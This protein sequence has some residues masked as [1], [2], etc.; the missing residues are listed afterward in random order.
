MARTDGIRDIALSLSGVEERASY[1]GLPSRRTNISRDDLSIWTESIGDPDAT[2][3]LLIAGANASSRMWPEEVV[4]GL[5]ARDYLVLRYDHRDTGRSTVRRFDDHPYSVGDLAADAVAVLDG[6]GIA[7]AHVVGFSL[8]GTIAQLLALD[9]PNRLLSVTVM[10]SAALDIDFAANFARALSGREASDGLPTPDAGVVRHLARRGTASTVEDEIQRRTDVARMLAR[11]GPFEPDEI[12]RR[13]RAA[14]AHAGTHVPPYQ[15]ALAH[16]VPTARGTELARVRTR[17]LVVQG[18][19]DPLNPPPH[20][21]HLARLIPGAQLVEFAELG[22]N[23]PGALLGEI[24]ATLLDHFRGSGATP[25]LAAELIDLAA[26]EERTVAEFTARAIRDADFGQVV[27]ERLGWHPSDEPVQMWAHF[28]RTPPPPWLARWDDTTDDEARALTI[29]VERGTIAL[30]QAV[31]EHGWPGLSLVGADGADAAWM[32][33]MHADAEPALQRRCVDLIE[34]AVATGDADPRHY[35]TLADRVASNDGGAQYFGTLVLPG[36]N[37]P[38]PLLEIVDPHGL[39]RRRS[40]IG[41]PRLD[42]D[43]TEAPGQLPY[44][45]L[46]RTEG[47]HWPRQRP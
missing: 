18:G 43:L 23:L 22:H 44:R 8:G 15:H 37:G 29:A 1:G 45:H 14:I 3:V 11:G 32:L 46:R 31:G 12:I 24:E 5:A 6:H 17:T 16:P 4:A 7:R 38:T 21:E 42:D 28:G 26:D 30:A 20:G 47:F 40:E 39:D 34:R 41:L 25:Y 19:R 33:A 10:C 36:P 35:A 13:E 27:R 9:W 2:P